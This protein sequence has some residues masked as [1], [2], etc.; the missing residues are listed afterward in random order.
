MT[1][2]NIQNPVFSL[3]ANFKNSLFKI[4]LLKVILKSILAAQ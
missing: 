3:I 4:N 1:E 2:K